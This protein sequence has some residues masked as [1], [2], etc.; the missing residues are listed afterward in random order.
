VT[1]HQDEVPVDDALARRLV[2]DQLPEWADLAVRPV[3]AWGTDNAVYRL[4]DD[5]VV[6]LPRTARTSRTLEMERYWLPRLAPRLPLA[7][8]VPLACGA[9]SDAY[10]FPWS[11]Y[12][13]LPGENATPDRVA[14]SGQ[15][16]TDLAQFVA[17][18]QRIELRD[19]PRPNDVNV[20]RGEALARRNARTRASIGSL[21]GELDT[22]AIAAVWDEALAAPGW[23]GQPVWLHGDLDSRNLLAEDGRLTGV[24]DFGT[25]SVG[26][27][28]WDVMV[29]WKMLSAEARDGF[30]V[31]LS[32]DD[33]TWSRSRGLAVAQAVT[34][35]AYYTEETNAVLVHEARSWVANVLASL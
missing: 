15:L 26:D 8:P 21:Q 32:V 30:R 27:P 11:V 28:A 5:M 12:R 24:I 13:W 16:A 7:V 9:P 22:V 17:A 6:R 2:A 33:G 10:P 20:F 31:T 4:G 1:M 29:A 23:D 14:D 19:G 35:L 3:T 18:M 25:L 34:A